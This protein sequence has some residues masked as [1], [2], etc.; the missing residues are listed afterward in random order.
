M[1]RFQSDLISSFK[2]MGGKLQKEYD[3]RLED[4]IRQLRDDCQREIDSHKAEREN[5]YKMK[6]NDWK[7]Q[8]E[9][10]SSA[11]KS[12]MDEMA[13]LGMH[14]EELSKKV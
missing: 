8:L 7:A 12:K 14:T 10:N 1:E 9:N 3:T 13:R 2:E 5:L 11:M 6:E 4:A